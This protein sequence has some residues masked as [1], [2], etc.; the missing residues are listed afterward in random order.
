M[1]NKIR[2]KKDTMVVPL[3]LE[4]RSIAFVGK[5]E[6]LTRDGAIRVARDIGAY[7]MDN[8]CNDTS[9]LV[10]G[11]TKG[12]T[13]TRTQEKAE[14]SLYCKVITEEEF[15][16]LVDPDIIAK[17]RRGEAASS[18]PDLS[19]FR[20]N[21]KQAVADYTKSCVQLFVADRLLPQKGIEADGGSY[22]RLAKMVGD[23]VLSV[24]KNSPVVKEVRGHLAEHNL[25]LHFNRAIH[26]AP[27]HEHTSLRFT[28]KDKRRFILDAYHLIQSGHV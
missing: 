12:G 6:S 3:R 10:V 7:P 8:Y 23:V 5:M 2:R 19:S 11:D 20:V 1:L 26:V 18:S 28:I 9:V 13:K 27:H 24:S 16:S 17:H 14:N 22:I 25:D 21:I 4:H 15:L